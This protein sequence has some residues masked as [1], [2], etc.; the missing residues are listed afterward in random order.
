MKRLIFVFAFLF[1]ALPAE[2]QLTTVSGTAT[3]ANGIPYAGAQMKM[4]LVTTAGSPV[5]GQPTV[6]I[7]NQAQCVSSGFGSAPCK[8][9]FPGTVG[10]FQISPTGSF[11]IN[12]QDNTQV[13]P[14]ATQW[15]FTVNSLGSPPPLGTGP[16][17]C[18][19]QV[20]I[21][22]S[23]QTVTLSCPALSTLGGSGGG[24]GG[25]TGPA[26]I[27]NGLIA[28]YKFLPSENPCSAV[29][30]SGAGNTATGCA[31]TSPTIL[32]GTGGL[33]CPGT[34]AVILPSAVNGAKWIQAMINPSTSTNNPPIAVVQSNN[35]GVGTT[36]GVGLFLDNSSNRAQACYINGGACGGLIDSGAWHAETYAGNPATG[37]TFGSYTYVSNWANI[38]ETMDTNDRLWLNGIEEV[39]YNF[40]QFG[41][42]GVN[43]S[44]YQICGS[45]TG[46]SASTFFTGT[47]GSILFY[48]R[49][50]S[51]AEVAQNALA[52]CNDLNGR[53]AY[54]VCGNTRFVTN[55]SQDANAHI[56]QDD[57]SLGASGRT[58]GWLMPI[59]G[60]A[61]Q[62]GAQIPIYGTLPWR[63]I[64]SSRSGQTSATGVNSEPRT[65][66]AFLS[67]QSGMN[68]LFVEFGRND[69]CTPSAG[70]VLANVAGNVAQRLN[71]GWSYVIPMSMADFTTGDACKNSFNTIFRQYPW[72]NGMFDWG[73]NPN[74]GADGSSTNTNIFSDG[75]HFTAAAQENELTPM[76]QRVVGHLIGNTG[77]ATAATYSTAA[78][79]A[80]ATTA[81]TESVQTV[82]L[83]FG[84]IPTTCTQG[85]QI[86]VAGT[87]P[88]GYSG[89][90]L[91]LSTT[92]T[93]VTY[94]AYTSS[95]GAIT[96]QGTANCVQQKYV[97]KYTK[98]SFAGVGNFTMDSC[99]GITGSSVYFKSIGAA[100]PTLIPFVN[101]ETID[102]ATSLAFTS[103][104]QVIQLT[105]T[106]PSSSTAQCV[107]I[108]QQ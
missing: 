46:F 37:E 59:N 105:A 7:N 62:A 29:D 6:T 86:T 4:Q 55:L 81:G 100:N 63:G 25:A 98:L 27:T 43:A 20:T 97:D 32:S 47:I 108:R 87:T 68:I 39:Y 44:P 57:D 94:T 84:A 12:L 14:A 58:G 82:T 10:P 41:S 40:K 30:Y 9:P 17:T 95:M 91:V 54:F 66:D 48:N 35:N 34:G 2:A 101:A 22:G 64:I 38:A 74:I 49:L 15:L 90:W 5:S 78:P 56:G 11:T 42:A 70:Q 79:A 31:G 96:V 36:G 21:S 53:G 69:N 76:G 106:V 24:G 75:T 92:A 80:V 65:I 99:Q 23:S 83:T 18:T 67:Q 93:Q 73:S 71:I 61:G 8:I 102:G 26:I 89:T 16:Q 13:T 88:A 77:W 33:S 52:Q 85:S 103:T 45:A 72:P 50:P 19:A 107:W 60:I 3:D 1:L 51:A 28:Y 104:N